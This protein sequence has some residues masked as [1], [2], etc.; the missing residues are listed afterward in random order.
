MTAP[1]FVQPT[2][3]AAIDALPV[4]RL[5]DGELLCPDCAE[6]EGLEVEEDGSVGVRPCEWCGQLVRPL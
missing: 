5:V 6:N 3:E 4:M 1:V 2:T